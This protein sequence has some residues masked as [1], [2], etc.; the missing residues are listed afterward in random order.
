MRLVLWAVMESDM[1]S[2]TG[3]VIGLVMWVFMGSIME[4]GKRTES[5]LSF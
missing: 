5:V 3:S 1:G 2:I 4:L